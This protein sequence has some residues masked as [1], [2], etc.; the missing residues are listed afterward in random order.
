VASGGARDGVVARGSSSGRATALSGARSGAT[1][2][3]GAHS[4]A[5][6]SGGACGS[7]LTVWWSSRR[8]GGVVELWTAA[9]CRRSSRRHG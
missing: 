7:G 2:S 6:T 5:T 9:P 3:G 4:G 1:A 8:L